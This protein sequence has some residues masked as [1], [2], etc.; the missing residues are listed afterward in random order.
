MEIKCYISQFNETD[1]HIA[2]EMIGAI[3]NI[4]IDEVLAEIRSMTLSIPA[5]NERIA[6]YVERELEGGKSKQAIFSPVDGRAVQPKTI[7]LVAPIRGRNK[8]G[9]EGPLARLASQINDMN[10][11][12]VLLSPGPE[13]IRGKK[14]CKHIVIITDIIGSGTRVTRML[15]AFYKV[16]TVRSWK[17]LRWIRF[18]IVAYTA[19]SEGKSFIRRHKLRPIVHCCR[20]LPT[21][22][23][24]FAVP[25]NG[26]S[27]LQIEDICRRYDPL[28]V[29]SP[30]EPLGYRNTGALLTISGCCPNN[31]PRILWEKGGRWKPLF[32]NFV[33]SSSFSD[34]ESESDRMVRILEYLGRTWR[35]SSGQLT[36]VW[37]EARPLVVLL[38]A[39]RSKAYSLEDL[40]GLIKLT[41]KETK[42]LLAKAISAGWMDENHKLTY[43]GRRLIRELAKTREVRKAL[44]QQEEIVYLPQQL[45]VP[46]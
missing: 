27:S 2:K 35:I 31:S 38:V 8:V 42:E 10:R 22:K 44:P 9:S 15:D 3:V 14:N 11:R 36:Q 46:V 18:H 13:L 45:R 40:A 21:I 16:A 23:T 20:P 25:R 39:M 24:E 12:Q 29:T 41:F 30:D 19:S 26:V 17:S 43:T 6:L 34:R 4:T 32:T 37:S 1:R 5:K 33:S 28:R 7:P